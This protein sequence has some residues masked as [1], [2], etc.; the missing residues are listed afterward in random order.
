MSCTSLNTSHHDTIAVITAP[1]GVISNPIAATSAFTIDTT[2]GIANQSAVTADTNPS[3][4]VVTSMILE[5]NSGFFSIHSVI[6]FMIS[7]T[8]CMSF[9][10]AGIRADQIVCDSFNCALSSNATFPVYP[11]A[12]FAASHT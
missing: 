7:V 12:I 3:T 1:I 6:G 9:V 10:I 8:D 5:L 4:Q 11:S 2:T